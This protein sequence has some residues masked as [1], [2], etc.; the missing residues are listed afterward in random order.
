ML[1]DNGG[2]GCGQFRQGSANGNNGY[3]NDGLRNAP[4]GGNGAAVIHQQLGADHNTGGT[5][6]DAQDI[7]GNGFF[8]DRRGF[9]R[10]S[11]FAILGGA[12]VFHNVQSKDEQQHQ[13]P[14]HR[15]GT[16]E[17]K[18]KKRSYGSQQQ[19]SFGGKVFALNGNGHK[20]NADG[21]NHGGIADDRTDAVADGHADLILR[22]GNVIA[23]AG[24]QNFVAIYGGNGGNDDLRQGGG[25]ANDGSADDKFGD[26]GHFGHPYCAVYKPIAA[27]YNE[28]HAHDKQQVHQESFHTHSPCL[29][30]LPDIKKD[31]MHNARI[32]HESHQLRYARQLA[33]MLT[34]RAQG[35]NYSLISLHS[36]I[37][38]RES[39]CKF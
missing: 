21:Q 27:F 16:A 39:Q 38:G 19:G 5:A 26:F 4:G 10:F 13:G 28:H 11:L 9:F 6:H 37:N 17:R 18:G 3:A 1:F 12:N 35:A 25:Y 15:E 22:S 30:L 14:D 33:S 7:G 32:V 8:I 24:N 29:F 34:Y 20:N 36:I 31:C 23:H 2:N